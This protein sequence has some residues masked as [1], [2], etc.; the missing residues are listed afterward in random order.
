MIVYAPGC[1]IQR[2]VIPLAEDSRVSQE[3]LCQPVETVKLSG[4][5]VPDV[6]VRN[7]NA[8]LVVTYM[9]RPKRM[10]IPRGITPHHG[11]HPPADAASCPY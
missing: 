4:H 10:R 1:E 9:A 6:L 3:F 2:F 8:E 5:I 11:G 7:T